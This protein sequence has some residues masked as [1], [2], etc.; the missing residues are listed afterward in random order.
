M[1]LLFRTG[2]L[3]LILLSFA[4]FLKPSHQRFKEFAGDMDANGYKIETRKVDDY[5]VYATFEK[6]AYQK[7]RRGDYILRYIQAF[8]GYLLNFKQTSQRNF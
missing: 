2:V 8:R 6:S 7:T 1:K 5:I 3:L 4:A